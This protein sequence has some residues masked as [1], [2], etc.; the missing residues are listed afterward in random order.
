MFFKTMTATMVK[1]MITNM[2]TIAAQIKRIKQKLNSHPFF[3]K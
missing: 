2:N 1:N 3:Q